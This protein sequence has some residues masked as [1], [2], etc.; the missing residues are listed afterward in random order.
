MGD[1]LASS[2]SRLLAISKELEAQ[3]E[4]AKSS[5]SEDDGADEENVTFQ[6]PEENQIEISAHEEPLKSVVSPEYVK[7]VMRELHVMSTEQLRQA[8]SV[9]KVSTSG[10]KRQLRKRVAQYYRKENM[11]LSRKL[12]NINSDKT[13]RY[14]DYLIA[15]DFECTC[16]EIIYDY[17]HEIIELPAVLIDVK[18]MK[19]VSM[20]RTYV[21]PVRNPI[22]SDFCIAFTKIA[23]ETVD[24][25]PYFREALQ[26]LYDWMRR[27]GLGEKGVRFA[28]VTDGP[29]DIF[30]NIKKIFKDRFHGIAKGNGK[31]GIEN[32][33]EKFDLKFQ[34]NKHSGLDDAKN[35]AYICLEMMKRKIE[36]R[37]N[38]RCV[39]ILNRNQQNDEYKDENLLNQNVDISRRDFQMWMRKL[40]L[41]LQVVS[42]RDFCEEKYLEC[43]SCEELTDEQNE[44]EKNRA[45]I[46]KLMNSKFEKALKTSVK[47]PVRRE[48][49][50]RSSSSS[51]SETYETNDD[52]DL[53]EEEDLFNNGEPG[54]FAVA[55]DIDDEVE[56]ESI[57]RHDDSTD[58]EICAARRRQ[59]PP[60]TEQSISSST[61]SSSISTSSSSSTVITSTRASD[62]QPPRNSLASANRHFQRFV[63]K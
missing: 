4:P 50:E 27:F 31:S 29:H 34:G 7:K 5:D 23:Q 38:Q 17:P 3:E 62:L 52:E 44:M 22:L 40:P 49:L 32:M 39:Y 20:F 51:D 60:N 55:E 26:L 58:N 9:I 57:W 46:E 61:S 59:H 6:I 12:E 48:D 18:E 42:R 28:F 8:L 54:T 1:A 45:E 19:I 30:I 11:L 63:S 33:L 37:I 47:I 13:L 36:L 24:K 56:L 35:I 14:F 16:V 15:I 10:T 2:F 21:R 43:E 25:A 41:K 53:T